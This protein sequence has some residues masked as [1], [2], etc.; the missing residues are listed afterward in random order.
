MAWPN[1]YQIYRPSLS[2]SF[3][4]ISIN[5]EI[6]LK[7]TVMTNFWQQASIS[8]SK[9]FSAYIFFLS[10][11][12]YNQFIHV[13]HGFDFQKTNYFHIKQTS[14]HLVNISLYFFCSLEITN[15]ITWIFCFTD[16]HPHP[17]QNTSHK[18]HRKTKLI[19]LGGSHTFD[20]YPCRSLCRKVP[21][22]TLVYIM[23]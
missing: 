14:M 10:K 5:N 11:S 17:P 9:I 6:T 18:N 22:S 21:M 2:H 16:T 1:M 19:R 23:Q 7:H 12:V 3:S 20:T 4:L 15:L 13:N 8:A